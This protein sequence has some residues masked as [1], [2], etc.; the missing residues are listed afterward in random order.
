[1]GRRIDTYK[2]DKTNPRRM[3]TTAMSIQGISRPIRHT[4]CR[5][6]QYD[7][8]VD[9]CH[10]VLLKNWCDSKGYTN[11]CLSDFNDNRKER[12]LQV[13]EAMGWTK[14][15]T[16]TYILR[17]LNGG[18]VQGLPNQDIMH[19]LECLDWFEPLIR[20][21]E[22]MRENVAIRYPDLLKK[23]VK[24]KGKEY[25]N[26]HGTCLSYLLTNL[27]NQ[28][29]NVMV[30]ACIK[31]NVK[32]S[33]LIYDGFQAYKDSVPDTDEFMRYL[34]SEIFENTGYTMKV[35]QKQ[36]TE[37][38]IVPDDYLDPGQRKE[39]ER[40]EKKKV[41]EE[42][43]KE[44]KT[45]QDLFKA[46]KQR[47]RELK[48]EQ[49]KTEEKDDVP[50]VK[51]YLEVRNAEIEYD[52]KLG[53]G[54]FYDS[55]RCLWVQFRS[56]EGLG[57]DMINTLD[58]QTAKN[59]TNAI[60]VVKKLLMNREDDLTKFNMKPGIVSLQGD[61]VLDMR[62]LHVRKREKE[63]Y[64][65]FQ[66]QSTYTPD[67]DRQ[68]VN[69]YIGDL[70]KTEDQA[71][72]DQVLEIIGYMFAGENNLKIVIMMIGTGDNGKS[73]FMEIVKSLMEQYGTVANPKI[74]I[75]PRFENNTH[76]A[77]MIPLIGKRGAFLSELGE[78]DELNA[79]AL[80]RISGN[81]PDSLRNSG[82]DLT[83][84]VTIKAVPFS[85]SNYVPRNSDP[86]LWKRLKIINFANTFEKSALKEAEIRGHRHDLFCAFMEGANRYYNR[87]MTMEYCQQITAFTQEKR[88]DKDPFIAFLEEHEESETSIEHNIPCKDVFLA[89]VDFCN[90]SKGEYQKV[91]KEIFYARLEKHFGM[92]KKRNSKGNFYNFKFN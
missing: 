66:L 31:R 27:E 2:Q 19:Q 50:L 56:F 74:F 16:K 46:E 12:F 70:L 43:K 83:L 26:L 23:A 82:S 35:S 64:C 36:M 18:G 54:Y 78:N 1:M 20:E 59:V 3:T 17:L 89:F 42:E 30:N 60:S 86:V 75:K 80:K 91:G 32:I 84:D 14:E 15:E 53:Y 49:K 65:S 28:V 81:D 40:L 5:S 22:S 68:W 25:Y 11:T 67:Y 10:P 63:D 88:D 76:E 85:A 13:Q 48:K 33:G 87:N 37:G 90:N 77:H 57:E 62:T 58:L 38:I 41:K 72:I 9:N 44:K 71:Y 45:E 52:K 21:L 7:F 55:K 39:I 24:A 51:E 73:L 4:L 29:L 8:D 61:Q 47:Q 34:E 69:T 92:V 6:N 79:N